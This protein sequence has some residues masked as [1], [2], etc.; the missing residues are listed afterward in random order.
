MEGVLLLPEVRGGPHPPVH[1]QPPPLRVGADLVQAVEGKPLRRVPRRGGGGAV[2]RELLVGLVWVRPWRRLRVLLHGGGRL[3]Q[4]LQLAGGAPEVEVNRNLRLVIF[5]K[6]F[7][8]FEYKLLTSLNSY[9]STSI[10]VKS[11]F[12]VY[13]KFMQ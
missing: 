11:Q 4:G 10:L 9:T 2:L 1:R 7:E 13:F 6:V 3:R 5:M 8:F 12:F